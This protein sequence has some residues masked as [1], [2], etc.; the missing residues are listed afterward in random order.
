MRTKGSPAELENRRRLAVQRFV[1]GCTTQEIADFLGVSPR[2]VRLWVAAF[3][4]HGVDGLDARPVQGRPRKLTEE[5]EQVALTWLQDNP[6]DHG[7]ANEL[8]TA[9]RVGQL[10]R[11]AWGI[12][13]NRRYL[14]TWLRERNITPQKPQR[15]PRE[16]DP[17]RIAHWLA[18]DWRRIKKKR[19]GGRPIWS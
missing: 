7:F 16:R 10:I 18:T 3:L 6:T 15:V 14:S 9:E 17:D 4:N 11:Q 13:F 2:A 5:Q 19:G 8:W 12:T 1:E